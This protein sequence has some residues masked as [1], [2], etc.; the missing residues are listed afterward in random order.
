MPKSGFGLSGVVVHG[1]VEVF[2]R[3]PDGLVVGRIER[4]EPRVGRD[5][6]EQDP[7]EQVRVTRSLD[8]FDCV[9]DVGEEDLGDPGAPARCARAEVGEPTVV[10]AE[11]GDAVLVVV[12]VRGLAGREQPGGE[13][14]RDRVRE[15]HLGDDAV[16]LQ[17]PGTT[18]GV[19]VAR[20]GLAAEVVE[21]VHVRARP[22]VELVE[23][24]LLEV[25]AVLVH[26]GAGVPVG[27][28]HDVAVVRERRHR[29]CPP[30]SVRIAR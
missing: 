1:H 23:P 2:A 24:P 30:W 21:R 12:A 8:L 29:K 18:V 6:R 19:P 15:E 11:A 3:G 5:A 4:W 25:V 27:R 22:L 20:R 16:V 7:A 26:L 28:D 13:E 10:G 17:L 14:R 9:V